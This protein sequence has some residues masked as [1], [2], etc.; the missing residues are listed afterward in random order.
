MTSETTA[1]KKRSLL[2]KLFNIAMVSGV[3]LIVG[4]LIAHMAWKYSGSNQWE[5][6]LDKNGVKVYSLKS[7]G[8][9]LKKFKMTTRVKT[10]LNR[11]VAALSD[12]SLENCKDWIPGCASSTSIEP[13]NPQGLYS[14]N[15][16][17][18]E[19]PFPFSPRDLVLKDQY[20]QD[21]QSK[22]VTVHVMA[23]PNVLAEN[24]C[25]VRV[26][27]MHNVWHWTPLKDGEVE[28]EIVSDLDT[29]LPY[30]MAN[31]R[32]DNLYRFG[33]RMQTL[34]DKEQYQSQKFDFIKEPST[35]TGA[36]EHTHAKSSEQ[37]SL[38]HKLEKTGGRNRL[39]AAMAGVFNL[40]SEGA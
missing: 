33:S 17:R 39:A 22:A 13:W 24:D 34:L 1:V 37:S 4:A 11:A 14:I 15:A 12:H 21:P 31:G 7:P 10:T 23:I 40:Q 19:L 6:E 32:V 2:G 25:C 30:I 8:S 26:R 16:Y 20:S 18:V 3:V 5:L 35:A 36:S 27:H 29:R 9:T 28:L 38:E